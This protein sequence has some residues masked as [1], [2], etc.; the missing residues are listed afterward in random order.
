MAN[1]M[2]HLASVGACAGVT[3]LALALVLCLPGWLVAFGIL[4]AVARVLGWRAPPVQLAL[5]AMAF[6]VLLALDACLLK[7]L[8]VFIVV[9]KIF[10]G[11]PICN[12]TYWR[13]RFRMHNQHCWF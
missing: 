7:L 4:C 1:F 12:R 9:K 8:A 13:N 3:A 6:Q 5:A 11:R 2:A 10:L